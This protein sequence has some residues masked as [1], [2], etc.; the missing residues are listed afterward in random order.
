VYMGKVEKVKGELFNMQFE[1]FP[2]VKDP[3][4]K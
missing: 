1:T 3:L 2:A 4:K